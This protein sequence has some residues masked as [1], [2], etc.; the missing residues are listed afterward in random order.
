LLLVHS[1]RGEVEQTLA[2]GERAVALG[3]NNAAI[4][5]EFGML[6]DRSSGAAQ[7]SS[8]LGKGLD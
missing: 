5:A 7:T 3:P 6:K 1:F 4:L 2:A 8:A